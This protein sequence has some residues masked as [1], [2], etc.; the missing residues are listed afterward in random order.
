MSIRFGIIGC[1][2]IGRRHAGH[3]KNLAGAEFTAAFDL[4]ANRAEDLVE[5]S[6]AQVFR[7]LEEFL[8]CDLDIVS[9]CTPNGNHAESAM[10]AL[11]AGKHVLI[12]KPM[13]IELSDAIEILDLSRKVNRR[14][15]VVKQ[16]RFNPPVQAVKQLIDNNQLGE[17]NSVIVNCLWNRNKDYYDSSDWRGTKELDGGTLFTQFSHFIDVLYFLLGDFEPVAG[18][19][20]NA[21]HEG[22]IEFEDTGHF[23][24]R[25]KS[26]NTIGSFNYSTAVYKENLEGSIS[27]L[28]SK[29]SVKIGGKYMNTIDYQKGE[30]FELAELPQSNPANNYGFYEGSMSNHDKMLAN[31]V[32]TLNGTEP[33]MAA[34]ED[35]MKVVEIIEAFY[36]IAKQV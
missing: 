34:G 25:T 27:I 14:V 28:G 23:L 18:V 19:T 17:I 24:I 30:D 21:E 11:K 1:G 12:E 9:I 15:F 33:I 36:K 35:G 13:C 16:N 26:G 4:L 31:V 32:A 6:N 7:S 10:A 29:G 3:L 20:R 22:M 2:H 5:S 8:T